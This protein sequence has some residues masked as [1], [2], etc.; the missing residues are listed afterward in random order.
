M[1]IDC[2]AHILPD[3]ALRRFPIP[4]NPAYVTAEPRA[5]GRMVEE[6]DRHGVTHA[7]VS[8]SFYMES[9]R[10]ALPSWSAADRAR[11]FNDGLAELVG[12][13]AGRLFGLACVDPWDG[14]P[15]ARELE[16]SVRE[17]G[18]VGALVNPA[19]G[20]AYLDSPEAEPLLAAAESLD[21]P[22]FLHPSRDLPAPE[23]SAEFGLHLSLARPH[24][25]ATCV[26][27]MIY[28]G[29]LDRHPRLRLLLAHGGGTLPYLAGRL[30]ATWCAYRPD[31]WLGPDL[32]TQP[33]STYLSRLA[34]DT[35]TWSA[36][37]IRLAIDVFGLHHVLFGNDYPP[38]WFSLA[39]SIQILDSAALPADILEAVRWRNAAELFRL[40]VG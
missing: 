38:V 31:R 39:E 6:H 33:P 13:H 3:A 36:A 16:R 10:D 29:T 1:L 28:G 30:D 20:G 5:L 11:L 35:N 21:V 4:D 7:V 22:L 34:C 8:D 2:H 26:A 27:R 9:S 19:N 32:L 12:R 23:H 14:E 15:S 17:L 37:A 18:L 25:T 40:P 24:Q